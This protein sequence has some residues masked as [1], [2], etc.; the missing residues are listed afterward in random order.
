[1]EHPVIVKPLEQPSN[2]IDLPLKIGEST[3][4]FAEK[5]SKTVQTLAAKKK[6]IALCHEESRYSEP[7]QASASRSVGDTAYLECL[8]KA[9]AETRTTWQ[10]VSVAFKDFGEG[11]VQF[12]GQL[13][14]PSKTTATIFSDAGGRC[15]SIQDGTRRRGCRELPFRR[16]RS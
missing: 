8:A 1:R 15:S 16:R 2:A 6:D 3:N 9:A 4:S 12:A 7:D 11:L 5:L 13:R 10:D 14:R